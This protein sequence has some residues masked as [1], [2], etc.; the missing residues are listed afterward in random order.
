MYARSRPTGPNAC[1]YDW[2]F[3][4]QST[5]SM[6]SLNV[7]CVCRRKS[8]SSIF[9][10]RLNPAIAGIV[11]SPTPTM[12][13]S[14]D[15]TTVMDMRGP[16][17]RTSA[18]AAIHPAVPPPAM[19]TERTSFCSIIRACQK[20]PPPTSLPTGVLLAGDD[21]LELVSQRERVDRA[22]LLVL[23]QLVIRRADLRE[24]ERFVREVDAL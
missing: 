19:T 15:S 17:T 21:R 5:N 23:D 6:P 11:A 18:A 10:M 22:V 1:M 12:P 7:P 2:P 8:S 4:H 20:K 13:I 9:T 3:C 24:R 16:S 14:D